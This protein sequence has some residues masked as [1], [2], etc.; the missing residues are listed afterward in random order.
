MANKYDK[1]L[2]LLALFGL[3][4]MAFAGIVITSKQA[5]SSQTSIYQKGIAIYLKDGK[6]SSIID[7]NTNN[8]IAINHKV[9]RYLFLKC[10]EFKSLV[11][12]LDSIKQKKFN[13]KTPVAVQEMMAE[14][15]PPKT[16]IQIKRSGRGSYQGFLVEKYQFIV[17]NEV[18]SEYWMSRSLK[19]KIIKEVD[20]DKLNSI[21]NKNSK[22][23][24][25]KD[26][27]YSK[28]NEKY[29]AF[30]KDRYALKEFRYTGSETKKIYRHVTLRQVKIR[31]YMPPSSYTIS[32]TIKEFLQSDA[33]L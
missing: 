4:Q 14:N 32:S 25:F 19:E 20:I 7:T 21:F 27:L 12:K 29:N 1:I 11:K 6:P 10:S 18:V 22:S 30:K 31:K 13:E 5:N 24:K 17:D 15:Q 23:V 26:G 3:D 33:E 16:P 8:C 9:K 2:L 28:I